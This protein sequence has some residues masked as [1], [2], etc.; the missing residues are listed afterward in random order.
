MATGTAEKIYYKHDSCGVNSGT[1]VEGFHH[2]QDSC[3]V[4]AETTRDIW[5]V[6]ALAALK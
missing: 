2:K 3:K 1:A 6:G 5:G 4:H